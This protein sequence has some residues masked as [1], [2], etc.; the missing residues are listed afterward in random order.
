MNKLLIIFLGA[1]GSGKTTNALL[2][3]R[4]LS[5]LGYKAVLTKAIHYTILLKLWHR[6]VAILT[7]RKV[8]YRF[9][10]NGSIE[11][12]VE[13]SLLKRLISLDYI[14]SLAS[15]VISAL[16]IRFLLMMFP[17]VIEH[18]GFI[19]NQLVYLLFIYRRLVNEEVLL[20]KYRTLL[21]FIPKN[22]LV[23]FLDVSKLRPEDLYFRYHKRGSL[24]EPWYYVKFQTHIYRALAQV[25]RKSVVLDASMDL[26]SLSNLM[27]NFVIQT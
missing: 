25:S 19:F 5:K 22:V 9:R 23:I 3:K 18:E 2:L 7:S 16:K 14:V 12:F 8:S 24:S 6:F 20:R 1:Q 15:A 27:L 10:P 11:E 13:P 26:V 21:S 4:R 17:I